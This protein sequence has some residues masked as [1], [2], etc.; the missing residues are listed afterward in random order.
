[1][2]PTKKQIEALAREFFAVG[3]AAAQKVESAAHKDWDT[4]Q[5]Y[6]KVGHLAMAAYVLE[7]FERKKQK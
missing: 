1:M 7:H 2:K 6:A 4:M 5:R 3:S